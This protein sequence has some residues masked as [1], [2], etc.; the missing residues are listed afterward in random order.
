MQGE[1]RMELVA[2]LQKQAVRRPPVSSVFVSHFLP[3]HLVGRRLPCRLQRP[4]AC[5]TRAAGTWRRP[6][7]VSELEEREQEEEEEEE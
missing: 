7:G 3:S 1:E 2:Q 6:C 5:S 4:S